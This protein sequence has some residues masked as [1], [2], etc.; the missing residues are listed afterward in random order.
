MV[1]KVCLAAN[2]GGH[3]NQLLQLEPFASRYNYF[4]ITDR[5]QF[6]E[7]LSHRNN[8]FF[9]EK[10]II[11]ECIKRRYFFGPLRNL[12]QSF[13]IIKREQPDIII[14]TGAGT[15]FGSCLAGKLLGKKVIFIESI[16]RV[17]EPST[18]G[19]I[20]KF[21]AST[22]FVQWEAMLNY[23]K[24]AIY[25]GIIFDL[26]KTVLDNQRNNRIFVTTGT[27]ELAFDRILMELDRLKK[28]KRLVQEVIAQSGKSTYRPRYF[29]TFE[30]APQAEIH[31]LIELSDIVICHG[32]SGSIM[33]SLL[34]GKKVIAVPRL[35]E[36]GEFFDNHQ[37][38]V[39]RELEK[40]NLII[41][42]YDILDLE[43]AIERVESFHPRIEDIP[44]RVEELLNQFIA[45]NLNAKM[46]W[47]L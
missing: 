14:T 34:R 6:S 24:S 43:N 35:R 15:A 21:I 4:F 13:S 42:V 44:N 12:W 33:D 9:V 38:Q 7:G 2:S 41:A 20:M 5:S 40:R 8:I 28:K 23:Y 1:I 29:E 47:Y 19:R 36:F 26:N 31:R 22:T 30:F 46:K 11:K 18:F 45:E 16:A 39:V 17:G 37:L 3:L 32:G 27:Y 10:F 25:S